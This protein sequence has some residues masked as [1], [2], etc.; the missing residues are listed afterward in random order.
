MINIF[1][2]LPFLPYILCPIESIDND[3]TCL[4]Q[5]HVE[6]LQVFLSIFL[7]FFLNF[8][9]VKEENYLRNHLK[10][11]L[12]SHTL[13]VITKSHCTNETL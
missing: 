8:I 12:F 2:S 9:H 11:D 5:Q 13:C 6:I 4:E 10:S 3:I 1:I 7:I